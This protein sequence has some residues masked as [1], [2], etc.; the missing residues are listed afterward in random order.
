MNIWNIVFL[1]L[2]FLLGVGVL[3]LGANVAKKQ[4][5]WNK[6]IAKMEKDI[7]A[8]IKKA[9]DAI[10]GPAKDKSLA[11]KD[12]EKDNGLYSMSELKVK[13]Q[14]LLY[15]RSKAWFH[16]KPGTVT[17]DGKSI[18][19]E[20]LFAGDATPDDKLKPV[21]LAEVKLTVMD[22]VN[23]EPVVVPPDNMSGVIYLFAKPD[24]S[25]KNAEFLGRFSVIDIKGAQVTLNS[26]DIL[27]KD[28]I[29]KIQKNAGSSRKWTVYST[30]PKDR[31]DGVLSQLSEDEIDTI[32]PAAKRD[33]LLDPN[34]PLKDFNE[35]LNTLYAWRIELQ[36]RIDRS[37]NDIKQLED[38]QKKAEEEID[39]LQA[40][41][42][43]EN[44]RIDAMTKQR[45]TVKLRL[46]DYESTVVKLKEVIDTAQKQNE[47]YV[48]RIAE[49][50]LKTA[51]KIQQSAEQA[52]KQ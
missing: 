42:N 14:D 46:A 25:G 23:D 51:A 37:N 35:L 29:E 19:P 31:V 15:E 20:Q 13:L 34:R 49:Y 17:A 36:N 9:Q 1:V 38:A 12:A 27:S 8:E 43:L 33:E 44:K 6:K 2:V 10:D 22:P 39:A 11:E 4:D 21:N 24:D 52:A 16:C 7:E 26:V 45:D 50:Q 32:I 3:V 40:D 47:W 28:E 41:K 18:T 48:A 30:A 5:D